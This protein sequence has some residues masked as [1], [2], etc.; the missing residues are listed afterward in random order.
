MS[1]WGA[2]ADNKKVVFGS[3][4]GTEESEV[5]SR[6]AVETD[7]ILFD[8]NTAHDSILDLAV[9]ERVVE[10]VKT[11]MR[12][13]LAEHLQ[14]RLDESR[15]LVLRKMDA[16]PNDLCVSLKRALEPPDDGLVV[17]R[18]PKVLKCN[19]F[20]KSVA[21]PPPS[22][23]FTP[24]V[25][26]SALVDAV[27]PPMSTDSVQA[28]IQSLPS[29][30]HGYNLKG[31]VRSYLSAFRG[32]ESSEAGKRPWEVSMSHM[33][34]SAEIVKSAVQILQAKQAAEMAT[35]E[36]NFAIVAGITFKGLPTGPFLLDEHAETRVPS[37]ANAIP[38]ITVV[39]VAIGEWQLN[40]S[41]FSLAP[42]IATESTENLGTFK[43]TQTSIV[44]DDVEFF[45]KRLPSTHFHEPHT[46]GG[47][48]AKVYDFRPD[49]TKRCKWYDYTSNRIVG[50]P[51]LKADAPWVH[52]TLTF[53]SQT[54]RRA[55]LM[56]GKTNEINRIYWETATG[57][58]FPCGAIDKRAKITEQT[59]NQVAET[60][61][62][63]TL[64]MG[65]DVASNDILRAEMTQKIPFYKYLTLEQQDILDAQKKTTHAELDTLLGPKSNVFTLVAYH[66]PL[67][68]PSE[69]KTIEM[70]QAPEWCVGQHALASTTGIMLAARG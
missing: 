60:I 64:R 22:E 13:N 50:N 38:D 42:I 54:E 57:V 52:S 37:Y 29:R 59:C 12:N 39:P 3:R 58:K 70:G 66:E 53:L 65:D 55:L 67:V 21:W 44:L 10:A 14:G 23:T 46:S 41:G 48:K 25:D 17:H 28:L 31:A 56:A 69:L 7:A 32:T 1:T 45:I 8:L 5:L 62:S 20:G 35:D 43:C 51:E 27:F 6:L 2:G 40:M 47:A 11:E 19:L 15:L 4:K 26:R 30:K 16:A 34:S 61:A 33:T 63:R 68:G 36:T 24:Q 18:P 49:A 9:N